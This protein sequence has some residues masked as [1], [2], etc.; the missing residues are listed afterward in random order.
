MTVSTVA[1]LCA[2][3]WAST[4][5]I[6]VSLRSGQK[7]APDPDSVINRVL[8]AHGGAEAI[9][10]VD[11]HRQEGLLVT[12]GGA[13]ARLYRISRGPDRLS[14][15][16]EYSDRTEIRV[17][18]DGSAWRGP[19]SNA[20]TE[21]EGPL[22]GAVVL[23]AARLWLPRYLDDHRS[24]VTI[25]GSA[26]GRTILAV[27]VGEGMDLRVFVDD[28]TGLIVRSESLLT[29]APTPIGFATDYSDYR[30]V[31]GVLFAFREE[32]FASGFHTGSVA[33]ESVEVNP[34]GARATLPIRTG[35]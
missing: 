20:L 24:G 17:L 18:E 26:E 6:G 22:Q 27:T 12:Q 25:A 7:A 29:A 1:L 3:M 14:V 4:S 8:E 15:L 10:A 11:S 28:E 19:A 23:Q 35:S 34:S 16:M 2:G 30:R 5:P 13:H 31:S 32:T 21:V 9:R 33:L